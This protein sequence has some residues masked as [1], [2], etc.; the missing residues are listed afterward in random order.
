MAGQSATIRRVAEVD[1]VVNCFERT[2]RGVLDGEL[3]RDVAAESHFPFANR[4]VLINNVDDRSDAQARA[5]AA[6]AR[7]ALDRS[8]FVADELEGAL[9]QT[10]LGRED[11]GR[12]AHYSDA[13]LVA[14]TMPGAPWLVYWDADV[15]LR[16]PA[17]WITPAIELME[18]DPR[19][20]VANPNWV[21]ATLD[22]EAVEQ[23]G[24]F[25]LGQGFS[26]Q[27]FLAR[28]SELAS[29]IYGQ[30]CL[31]LYRYPL[32]HVA[33][34]FEARVDAYMRH[35][36]RLRATYR[37]VTY[38]HPAEGAGASYPAESMRERLRA[39][40]HAAVLAALRAS[41]VRPRCCRTL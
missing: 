26:D 34:V 27:L 22:R 23:A 24:D 10:G 39:I 41:P 13:P 9:E 7:G 37:P 25:T 18:R 32:S 31:A 16:E 21:D 4:T 5:D 19:V 28:R 14:V 12:V 6:V 30:R 29:P 20:L 1:L 3:L 38:V 33:D 40:R 15:H 35:A 17:D 11:L 2:Y 36:D 8:V